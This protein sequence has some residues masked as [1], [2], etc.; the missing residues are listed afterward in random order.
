MRHIQAYLQVAMQ[1]CQYK[2]FAAISASPAHSVDVL[3]WIY[4]GQGWP[5]W[6]QVAPG[7]G[8]GIT[9]VDHATG[10]QHTKDITL[11]TQCCHICQ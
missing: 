11:S 10:L 4:A 6:P 1:K 7:V 2:G 8:H 3:Q 5:I 9:V